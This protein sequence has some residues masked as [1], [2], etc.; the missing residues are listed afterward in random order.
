V[1]PTGPGGQPPGNLEWLASGDPASAATVSR[2]CAEHQPALFMATWSLSE[3]PLAV[4]ERIA[5]ALAGFSHILCAYQRRF[6]EHDNVRYFQS[7][8]KSLPGFAWQHA[9]CPI[10]HGNFYLIG[11]RTGG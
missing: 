8:E 7:L 11:K 4:R 3:T 1:F 9:E 10:F 5:P 6:G 2:H